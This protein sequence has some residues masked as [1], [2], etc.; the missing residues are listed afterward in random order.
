MGVFA[1]FR[2]AGAT[3][4]AGAPA[5]TVPAVSEPAAPAGAW[6]NTFTDLARSNLPVARTWR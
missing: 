2:R 5:A 1:W 3:R 6:V 4:E